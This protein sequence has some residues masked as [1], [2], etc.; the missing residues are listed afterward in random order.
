[1]CSKTTRQSNYQLQNNTQSKI[2]LHLTFLQCIWA[3][4][5]TSLVII[6]EAISKVCEHICLYKDSAHIDTHIAHTLTCGG[7]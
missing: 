7:W 1:V 5:L 2:Y 3:N 6:Y 4:F